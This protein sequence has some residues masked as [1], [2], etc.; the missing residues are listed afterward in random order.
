VNE[1]TAILQHLQSDASYPASLATLVRV[2]GSSYRRAG[3]RL[4]LDHAG[5]RLGS[6]SGGCLEEDLLVR[7]RA[8]T[9]KVSA[10][11][12][13]MYDTTAE[14]DLVWGVGLG[15]HGVVHIV[16][17]SLPARPGWV[18]AAG[19]RLSRREPAEVWVDDQQGTHLPP[20]E[21]PARPAGFVDVLQPPLALVVC[22]AGDDAQPL[23]RLSKTLGWTVQVVDPRAAFATRDRFPEADRVTCCAAEAVAEVVPTDDRTAAV[24]M[25]HHYRFDLPM[26]G[27]LRPLGLA[28]L[29]LLGP[30]RRAERLLTELAP[31]ASR[32]GDLPTGFHAPVGL[33]L[34]GDGPEAVAL[35]ILAEIQAKF[36]GRDA[37]PLRERP[38]PIHQR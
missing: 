13:V 23:V 34:G 26:L 37:R 21:A 10:P 5:R 29:G 4:L 19:E 22:G 3:A 36:A 33:D 25:T 16:L 15:C 7:L 35:A 20:I 9:S 14:N 1:I 8:R 18:A 6:I 2:E 12:L 11:E 28:Y 27:A 31:T 38:G 17:E 30:R 32:S 24:I